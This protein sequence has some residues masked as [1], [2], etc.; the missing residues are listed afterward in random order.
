MGVP[1]RP[2][3]IPSRPLAQHPGENNN[4][5]DAK[6]DISRSACRKIRS[7]RQQVM[8]LAQAIAY[9][10]GVPECTE[11]SGDRIPVSSPGRVTAGDR[12]DLA[13]SAWQLWPRI[14]VHHAPYQRPQHLPSG[15]DT[16]QSSVPARVFVIVYAA[17][18]LF[19]SLVQLF[20]T[21]VQTSSA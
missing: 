9:Q 20:G 4:Q 15:R 17:W 10:L 12:S 11:S 5:S 16:Y 14:A 8:V 2:T 7:G 6:S 3:Y 21:A 13:V 19:R 1:G 18:P